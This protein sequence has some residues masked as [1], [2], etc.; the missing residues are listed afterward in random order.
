MKKKPSILY[1][2]LFGL[3]MLFL[4][5]F[6]I[7]EHLKPFQTQPLMGFF[8]EPDK[9]KFRWEWYKNGYFQS[10]ARGQEFIIDADGEIKK[11]VYDIIKKT[12]L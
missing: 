5:S 8:M 12:A 10:A 1:P 6:M 9:P 2:L 11:W 3:L 4:F 7:Q